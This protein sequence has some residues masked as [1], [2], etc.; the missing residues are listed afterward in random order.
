MK[1][2]PKTKYRL[3]LYD[4]TRVMFG[5]GK[6]PV[7]LMGSVAQS[8]VENKRRTVPKTKLKSEYILLI[9]I[10]SNWFTWLNWLIF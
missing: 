2:N 3:S 7:I 5:D 10:L 1:I 9:V 6:K 4:S 8:T